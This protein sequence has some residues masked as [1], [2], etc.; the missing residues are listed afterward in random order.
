M[1]WLFCCHLGQRP[2]TLL[3]VWHVPILMQ[4]MPLSLISTYNWRLIYSLLSGIFVRDLYFET[5]NNPEIPMYSLIIT[6]SGGQFLLPII[7]QGPFQHRQLLQ[8][9][10][11]A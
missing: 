4:K 7:V 8:F 2:M 5:Y 1:D 10:F 6:W 11:L 3:C 9:M